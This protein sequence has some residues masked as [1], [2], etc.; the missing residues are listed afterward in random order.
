MSGG[1]QDLVLNE[2]DKTSITFGICL[3]STSTTLQREL[4]KP[5]FIQLLLESSH[6]CSNQLRVLGDKGGVHVAVACM[7]SHADPAAA[8]VQT[9]SLAGGDT[10]SAAAMSPHER[11]QVLTDVLADVR[12]VGHSRGLAGLR[13]GG[14]L[15]DT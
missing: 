2:F 15:V 10:H 6:R 9:P 11:A 12:V 14:K 7:T 1:Y 3:D 5:P 8:L 13:L 4:H